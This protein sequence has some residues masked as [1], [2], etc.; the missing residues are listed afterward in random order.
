MYSNIG[1][2]TNNN[3]THTDDTE[4]TNSSSACNRTSR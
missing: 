4:R 2:H 1:K 3:T